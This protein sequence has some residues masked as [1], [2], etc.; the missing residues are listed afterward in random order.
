MSGWVGFD[1]DGTL[2]HY[3]GW[4]GVSH[5]GT[6]VPLMI[7]RLKECLAHGQRVKIFTA[8]V[9]SMNTEEEIAKAKAA[10]DAW[11]LEHVGQKLEITAEKDYHMTEFYDDR[12]FTVEF[13]TGRYFTPSMF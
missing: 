1:L 7:E 6:P 5:I 11:C 8:R 4:Q 10:I 12:A 2:A 3:L 13:N 9:C